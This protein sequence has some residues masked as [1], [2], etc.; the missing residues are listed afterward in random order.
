MAFIPDSQFCLIGLNPT[1]N[2]AAIFDGNGWPQS[3]ILRISVE[4]VSQL[5]GG[6]PTTI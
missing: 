4:Q 2:N 3:D 1:Y 5:R 6:I